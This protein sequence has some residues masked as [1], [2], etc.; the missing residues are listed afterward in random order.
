M[1]L[2]YPCFIPVSDPGE[3]RGKIGESARKVFSHKI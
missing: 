3:D 2:F 1:S